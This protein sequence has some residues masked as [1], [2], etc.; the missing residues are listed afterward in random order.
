MSIFLIYGTFTLVLS[1][2]ILFISKADKYEP[3]LKAKICHHK[4]K[5]K[6]VKK[7]KKTP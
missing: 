6:I 4:S 7:K 5:S 3:E 1:N 2:S